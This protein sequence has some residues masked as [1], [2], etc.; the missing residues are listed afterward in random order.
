MLLCLHYAFNMTQGTTSSS[1]TRECT[2]L[3][4]NCNGDNLQEYVD[5]EISGTTMHDLDHR[6]KYCG[7]G[8]P[9]TVEDK[10]FIMPQQEFVV[11]TVVSRN[12]HN[13]RAVSDT[14]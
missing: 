5:R 14:V 2:Q 13:A 11:V 10:F 9:H 8:K 4:F 7:V 1:E 12:D 3:L 6:C